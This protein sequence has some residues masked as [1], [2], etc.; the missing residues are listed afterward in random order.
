MSKGGI[1]VS[2]LPGFLGYRRCP[3]LVIHMCV[4][5]RQLDDMDSLSVAFQS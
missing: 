1:V 5:L 2:A 3:L 4:L